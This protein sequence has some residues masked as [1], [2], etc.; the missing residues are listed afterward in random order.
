MNTTRL[1]VLVR[2]DLRCSSMAVQAGH[3][4]AQYCIDNPQSKWNNAYLIYLK[5]RDIEELNYYKTIAHSNNYQMSEFYEPDIEN[6]M[7]AIAIE[8]DG[9]IFSDLPLLK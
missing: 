2:K 6:E 3:A 5:V 8:C 4:V 1:Y 9:E 7:T